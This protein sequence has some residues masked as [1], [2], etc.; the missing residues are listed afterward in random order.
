[1]PGRPRRYARDEMVQKAM[2]LFWSKGYEAC[3]T[4]ALCKVMDIGKGSFYNTFESKH[5]LYEE[6]LEYYHEEW[7]TVQEKILT[8]PIYLKE[9]LVNFLTWAMEKDF[10]QDSNGCYLVNASAEASLDASVILWSEKHVKDLEHILV[11]EFQKSIVMGEFSK[12]YTAEELTTQ[13]LCN[14]YGLR[15][16]IASTRDRKLAEQIIETTSKL[17]SE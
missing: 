15:I 10:Q 14:F 8:E 9:R 2:Y 7:I 12:N 4:D 5:R 1:M 11:N 3:S 6:T 13:F 17:F 16:L